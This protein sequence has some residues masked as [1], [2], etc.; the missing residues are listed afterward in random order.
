MSTNLLVSII[1]PAKNEA[2]ALAALLPKLQTSIANAEVIVVDDGSS[3]NTKDICRRA[4]VKLAIHPYSMG[5]GA[6]IKTG[7]RLAK[8]RYHP[9]GLDADHRAA[10]RDFVR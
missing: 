4:G 1:L 3:D 6:A 5:N 7:A 2:L 9:A 8:G 10:A